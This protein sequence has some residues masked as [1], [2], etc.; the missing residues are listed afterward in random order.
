MQRLTA[1]CSYGSAT[2]LGL[3]G[4]TLYTN[5]IKISCSAYVHA[6]NAMM[7]KRRPI[8]AAHVSKRSGKPV[9]TRHVISMPDHS[10]TLVARIGRIEAFPLQLHVGRFV[11]TRRTSLKWDAYHASTGHTR[12]DM[13]PELRASETSVLR[14]SGTSAHRGMCIQ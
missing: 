14:N 13:A 11:C 9:E 12:T 5:P 1:G 2:A 10:L 4:A 3:S 7:T 8:R 6:A